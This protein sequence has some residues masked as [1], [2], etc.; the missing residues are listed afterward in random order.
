[1]HTGIYHD[2]VT[3]EKFAQHKNALLVKTKLDS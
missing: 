3:A 2:N 1:M